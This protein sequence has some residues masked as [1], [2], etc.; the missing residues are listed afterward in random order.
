M[1]KLVAVLYGIM[2]SGSIA[3]AQT[4]DRPNIKPGDFWTYQTT[5][6]QTANQVL[7][8][9]AQWSEKHH[10]V[11]VVRTGSAG[12]L[13]SKQERGSKQPPVEVMTGPDWSKYRTIDGEETV[14]SLPLKFPLGEG[15]KWE[16]KF[17]ENNPNHEIRHAETQLNYSVIGWE[18]ISVPAG[19]FKAL[20]IEAEGK[21]KSERKP[22]ASASATRNT[23]QDGTVLVVRAGKAMPQT[24]AGRLYRAYWYAPE[25]KTCV[26]AIEERFFSSGALSRRDT[27][28]LESFKVSQ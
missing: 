26:K 10:E 18:E 20:K 2:F 9:P 12:I 25:T 13:I 22:S 11:R 8:T 1:L 3:F 28:V 6:D 16:L 5:V 4:V 17:A 23:N 24:S 27:E 7:Q 19:K 21:W 14:V 15:K